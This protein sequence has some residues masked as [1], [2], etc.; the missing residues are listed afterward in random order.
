MGVVPVDGRD[1]AD[2]DILVIARTVARAVDIQSNKS[3]L[4]NWRVRDSIKKQ[5]RRGE[6]GSDYGIRNGGI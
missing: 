3:P 2:S 5:S 4:T 6:K 1:T